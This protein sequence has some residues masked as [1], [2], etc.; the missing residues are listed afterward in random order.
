MRL[1]AAVQAEPAAVHVIFPGGPV[2]GRGAGISANGWSSSEANRAA[3]ALLTQSA[4]Q[5]RAESSSVTSSGPAVPGQKP[6][7]WIS[8]SFSAAA[9]ASMSPPATMAPS[10]ETRCA[11]RPCSGRCQTAARP[12]RRACP[13]PGRRV[14][15]LRVTEERLM[16]RMGVPPVRQAPARLGPSSRMTAAHPAASDREADTARARSEFTTR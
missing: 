7:F 13:S 14:Q 6:S 11:T 1:T 8:S 5:A 16:N 10:A 4:T 9:A 2:T 12:C 3:P 15:V